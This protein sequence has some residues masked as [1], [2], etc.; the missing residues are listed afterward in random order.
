MHNKPTDT[1]LFSCSDN[2]QRPSRRHQSA[3]GEQSERQPHRFRGSDAIS[4]DES[5]HN[6]TILSHNVT[7]L[8]H[9]RHPGGIRVRRRHE[10]DGSIRRLLRE[11]LPLQL[12]LDVNRLSLLL[13]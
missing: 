11:L 5:K 7:R 12:L 6:Q 1:F 10:G 3:H 9:L 8:L 2:I 4:D 13:Q